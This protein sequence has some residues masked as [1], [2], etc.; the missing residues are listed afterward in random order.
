MVGSQSQKQISCSEIKVTKMMVLRLGTK[1][2]QYVSQDCGMDLNN[3]CNG[4]SLIEKEQNSCSQ[5]KERIGWCCGQEWITCKDSN[6]LFR[7]PNC[8]EPGYKLEHIGQR[9]RDRIVS[10]CF[11]CCGT[12][13]SP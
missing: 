12:G 9:G 3:H 8:I 7:E 2:I 13:L 10:S 6:I 5:S 1:C 4:Y 11:A